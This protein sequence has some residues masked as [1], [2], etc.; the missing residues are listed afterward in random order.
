MLMAEFNR[1]SYQ[2]PN[3]L[4]KPTSRCRFSL[5]SVDSVLRRAGFYGHFIFTSSEND[6]KRKRILCVGFCLP[7]WMTSKSVSLE[8][9]LT[10]FSISQELMLSECIRIQNRVS[11]DSPLMTAC[12]N[13][14]VELI[15]QH[16]VDGN[17]HVNDRTLCSGKTP[18][19]VSLPK[20]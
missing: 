13:G 5:L 18:L 6:T 8:I 7:S 1:K 19:L 16:L 4:T 10:S 14:D 2:T 12:R 20:I 15:R 11:I 3:P 9:E 17:G